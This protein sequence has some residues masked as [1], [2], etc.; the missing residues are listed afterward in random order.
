MGLFGEQT[1]T[2]FPSPKQQTT[3]SI[4]SPAQNY[5]HYSFAFNIRL[6]RCTLETLPAE[7][8]RTSPPHARNAMQ[9]NS[10]QAGRLFGQR[11]EVTEVHLL[12]AFPRVENAG[13]WDLIIRTGV[14][15]ISK[16]G[17]CANRK[18]ERIQSRAP[19][20]RV[21]TKGIEGGRA[22]V[23][24]ATSC[25]GVMILL[26]SGLHDIGDHSERR[27]TPTRIRR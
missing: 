12:H 27:Q 5:Q 7:P 22:I 9:Q 16:G 6:R 20:P 17:E 15:S 2:T 24:A 3:H 23:A 8:L 13:G 26:G 18:R 21:D 19:R 25:K 11:R 1:N 4:T 14:S 10:R